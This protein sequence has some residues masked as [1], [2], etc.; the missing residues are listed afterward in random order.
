GL[1]VEVDRDDRLRRAG[2]ER[3]GRQ[4]DAAR[5]LRAELTLRI[6]HEVRALADL[7]LE[8]GRTRGAALRDD[9]DHAGRR[10]GAVERRSRGPLDDLDALDVIGVDVVQGAGV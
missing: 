1:V 2:V 3:R 6:P 5:I 9:L 7:E 8:L 4:V 10:L